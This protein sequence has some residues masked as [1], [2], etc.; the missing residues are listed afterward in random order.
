MGGYRSDYLKAAMEENQPEFAEDGYVVTEKFKVYGGFFTDIVEH[1]NVFE[2]DAA[3]MDEVRTVVKA[4]V[5]M[6]DKVNEYVK[7]GIV[8]IFENGDGSR[9]VTYKGTNRGAY[10]SLSDIQACVCRVCVL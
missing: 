10:L 7:K 5:K 3:G 6:N 2:P 8:V 9:T 1:W 4:G